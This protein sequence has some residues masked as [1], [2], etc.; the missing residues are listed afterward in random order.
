MGEVK[1]PPTSPGMPLPAV[2]TNRPDKA[3]ASAGQPLPTPSPMQTQDSVKTQNLPQGAPPLDLFS[4]QL[5]LA[6]R[7]HERQYFPDQMP[8]YYPPRPWENT[9]SSI[10]S[11]QMRYL[12]RQALS[13]GDGH[14]ILHLAKTENEQQLLPDIKAGDMLYNAYRIGMQRVDPRLL[15]DIAKYEQSASLM[16]LKAG[17][18]LVDSHQAA[19][20]RQDARALFELAKYENSAQLMTAK[21]GDIL[22]QSYDVALRN[23]DRFTLYDIA[24]FESENDLLKLRAQDIRRIAEQLGWNSPY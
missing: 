11:D 21:A 19:E 7:D 4:E 16:T 22:Q 12:Y 20:K 14:M 8:A 6:Y 18:I 13:Y 23:R 2:V 1:L 15:L 9:S 3:A 5:P 10:N 24:D 17:D